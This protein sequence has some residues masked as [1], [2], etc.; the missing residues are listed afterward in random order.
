M[1]GIATSRSASANTTFGDLPPS[2]SLTGTR[3]RAAEA[4]IARP[5]AVEPTKLM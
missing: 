4:M 2:S 3:F 1:A 5:V